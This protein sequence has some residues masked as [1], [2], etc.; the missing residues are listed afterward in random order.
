MK[1]LHISSILFGEKKKERIAQ[2]GN[3]EQHCTR[4]CFYSFPS[5]LGGIGYGAQA[6]VSRADAP[7][8]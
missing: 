1:L 5:A 4:K 8:G 7:L 3:L 6:G 2:L